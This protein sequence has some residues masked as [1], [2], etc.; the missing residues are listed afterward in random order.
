[1]LKYLIF[2]FVVWMGYI[3]AER[4]SESKK[5]FDALLQLVMASVGLVGVVTF[6]LTYLE[7]HPDIVPVA[8]AL[9][10]SE[11]SYICLAVG[12]GLY[13]LKTRLAHRRFINKEF[14]RGGGR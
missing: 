11:I 1:M 14:D 8:Y 5:K 6:F 7:S 3:A 2:I 12:I 9:I 4:L 13:Y 10:V